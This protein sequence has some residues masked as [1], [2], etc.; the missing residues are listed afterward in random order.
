LS[1][2]PSDSFA[3]HLAHLGTDTAEEVRA[4]Y[5]VPLGDMLMFSTFVYLGYRNRLQPT[6]H[7][8]L[9][10]FTTLSLLDAGFDRWPVFAPYPLAV[11]NLIC[12]TPLFLLLIGYDWWSTGKVQRLTIWA[13][14]FM[15][16]VQQIRH[17]LGHTATWQRLADWVAM[18]TPSLF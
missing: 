17:P 3:R 11:V 12:F 14:I 5:A 7:K 16:F 18:R 9:M 6:V 10:W 15:V 1:G 4:F 13:T 8:R 2:K